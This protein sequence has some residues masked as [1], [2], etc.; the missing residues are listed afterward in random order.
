VKGKIKYSTKTAISRIHGTGVFSDE[1]IPARRK[2]GAMDGII[3]KSKEANRKA[4]EVEVLHLVELDNGS[5]LDGSVNGNDLCFMNHSC[6]PNTFTRVIGRHVEFYAL[7]NIMPGEELTCSYG[8]SYH[9][10]KRRCTCGAETC[11]GFL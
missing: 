10:G 4:R 1:A 2:I 11:E 3:I 6:S 7:R 5:V 8:E 9:E